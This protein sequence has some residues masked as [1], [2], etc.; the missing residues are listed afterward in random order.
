MAKEEK[1]YDLPK[2]DSKYYSVN[3]CRNIPLVSSIN[4]IVYVLCI[5]SLGSAIYSNVRLRTY[6]ERIKSLE[7][8]LYDVGGGLNL[9][10]TS[11]K[12]GLPS[13]TS[14]FSNND[15]HQDINQ[16]VNIKWFPG[17]RTNP[18]DLFHRLQHQV[19][20]LQRLRRDVSQ[21]QLI[22]AR[23]Q[24]AHDCVCPAGEHTYL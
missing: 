12:S 14:A 11:P 19:A 10:P 6:D 23:R 4:F 24:V 22:R 16:N 5:A 8:F 13:V 9:H 15:N 18:E 20:G 1:S 21:L 7:L 17:V 3:R 2:E